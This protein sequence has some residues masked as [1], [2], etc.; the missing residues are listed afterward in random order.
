MTRN[1]RKKKDDSK[2]TLT[3]S[4]DSN[5]LGSV[6]SP[7]LQF[8]ARESRRTSTSTSISDGVVSDDDVVSGAS[9]AD[10]DADADAGSSSTHGAPDSTLQPQEYIPSSPSAI[11]ASP[12][13]PLPLP[14]SPPPPPLPKS[15]PPPPPQKPHPCKSTRLCIP[16]KKHQESQIYLE[17]E[18]RRK[19]ERK[20]IL[21]RKERREEREK[22]EEEEEWREEEERRERERQRC[23]RW[24]WGRKWE[25]RRGG[26]GSGDK[27]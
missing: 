21:M 20:I 27:G 23:N 11:T 9:T 6:S 2:D 1:K 19:R 7:P 18:K 26:V 10:A 24:M 25:M 4:K 17:E 16:S 3:E 12:S 5:S 22:R 14:P 15:Q 13:P 8:P